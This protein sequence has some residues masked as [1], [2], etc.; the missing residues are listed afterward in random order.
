MKKILIIEDD[1]FLN[2]L[3]SSK[4]THEGFSVTTAMTKADID[5]ALIETSPDVI[6]LDLMLPEVDGYDILKQVKADPKTKD[7]PVIVFSNLSGDEEMKKVMEAGASAF[8]MKSN[9]TLSDVIEKI[10]SVT[11]TTNQ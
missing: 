5:K 10:I 8:M 4:F 6:L 7:I 9:F 2:N 11:T 3:E 1:S